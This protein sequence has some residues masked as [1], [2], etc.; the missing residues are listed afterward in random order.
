MEHFENHALYE[1]LRI[2]L[3]D[4][5][6]PRCFSRHLT[7]KEWD[8]LH[9]ECVKQALLGVVYRA[10]CLLPRDLQ[11]PLEIA[12]QWA[13]EAEAIK[14]HNKLLNA[15]AAWLT[16]HFAADGHKTAVLKGPANARL[17][18]DPNIRQAGDIDLWVDGGRESVF[19]LLKKL[20]YE[21]QEKDLIASSHHVQLFPARN[22]IPVEIHYRPT[23]G[24]WNPFTRRRVLRFLENEIQNVERVSEG[25]YVPSV[26][27]AL[28]MQLAHIHHHFITE[29]VG[30]KQIIDYYMLLKRSSEEDRCEIAANLSRFG[31]LRVCRALM[32]IMDYVFELDKSKMLCEPNEKHGKKMLAIVQ[33]DGSFG[34]YA[35]DRS[36][37]SSMNFLK[38]WFRY[39]WRVLRMFWFDPF[40]VLGCEFD[41]C[42][43]FVKAIGIRIKLRRLSLWGM[44]HTRNIDKKPND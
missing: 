32:W 3:D 27:F 6:S 9:S 31:L 34:A 16:D 12:F 20:G 22:N 36:D 29:G 10:I 33:K 38:R 4:G 26:K 40:E 8:N 23:S 39:R 37:E 41:Y 13:S 44:Y 28:V 17:Y 1:L 43:R 7:P 14:G 21:I 11:P 35:A 30:F 2:A 5:R 42:V 19:A 15:E 18:P 24:T 25:F